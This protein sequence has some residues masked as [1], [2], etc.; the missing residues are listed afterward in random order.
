MALLFDFIIM[1]I[2][3]LYLHVRHKRHKKL[4]FRGHVQWW[5]L[6]LLHD[7]IYLCLTCMHLFATS[8]YLNICGW[9]QM[10]CL[11]I[12]TGG[13]MCLGE[14]GSHRQHL[15]IVAKQSSK[16]VK[17]GQIDNSSITHCETVIYRPGWWPIMKCE[18][19]LPWYCRDGVNVIVNM[20]LRKLCIYTFVC[21]GVF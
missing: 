4:S 16:P 2:V 21:R 18:Y 7:L 20:L 8:L 19:R 15:N 6:L 10:H 12:L 17:L 14:G 11:W 9:V 13:Q 3:M 1:I 5:E